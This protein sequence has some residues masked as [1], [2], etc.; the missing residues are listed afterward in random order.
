MAVASPIRQILNDFIAISIPTSIWVWVVLQSSFQS[1][2]FSFICSGMVGFF[3]WLTSVAYG[4]VR[5]GRMI[6]VGVVMSAILSLASAMY[7]ITM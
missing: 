1:G 4:E 5:F 2:W 3:L 6:M 7:R